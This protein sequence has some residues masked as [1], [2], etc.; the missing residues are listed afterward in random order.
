MSNFHSMGS[1]DAASALPI[2]RR[3]GPTDLKD[4]LAKGVAD[5]LA[6]P[7]S[8]LFFGLV[9]PIYPIIGI[10]VV[11]HAAHLLF[12]IMS[13]F[14]LVGSFVAIGLYEVSRRRELGLE[15]SWTNVFDVRLSPSISSILG[16]G[17]LL[18]VIFICWLATAH[19]LYVYL[20]GPTAP[21]SYWEFL[22]EV[23]TT[24]RGWALI[25]IGNA[26]DFVFAAVV[27]SIS[28]VSFPL[29][30][31]RDVGLV[32]AVSTSIRTV[33]ANPVTIGL[34]GLIVATS[35]AI[36][37]LL[38]LVGLAFVVPILAHATWH[39]YRKVVQPVVLV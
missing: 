38:L 19:A 11:D 34:W 17:L 22:H 18:L 9:Y 15:I 25:G 14:A 3:I 39:L 8:L 24:S 32:V 1:S 28:V 36:G 16:L 31:D 27:L 37:F 6:M 7:S 26:I 29:L 2:V 33:L 10:S 13:G 4:V 23:L 30:L 20:F 12:P 35:L 21:V 5:F